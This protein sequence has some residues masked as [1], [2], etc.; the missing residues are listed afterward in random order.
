LHNETRAIKI[1]LIVNLCCNL[2]AAA[3]VKLK[4]IKGGRQ[5]Q[6]AKK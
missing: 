5:V 6:Q 1:W 4:N 3:E 2:I